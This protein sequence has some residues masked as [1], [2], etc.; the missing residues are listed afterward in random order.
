MRLSPAEPAAAPQ[1]Q[2]QQQQ[3]TFEPETS[4]LEQ[5]LADKVEE[6]EAGG[7]ESVT[8]DCDFNYPPFMLKCTVLCDGKPCIE[9]VGPGPGESE[10]AGDGAVT[11]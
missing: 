3:E 8:I 5:Q 11:E 6:L 10:Q 1:V 4:D 9:S 2:Q 7:A